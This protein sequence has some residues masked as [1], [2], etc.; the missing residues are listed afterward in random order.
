MKRG[1]RAVQVINAILRPTLRRNPDLKAAWVNAKA[2]S[3]P[4]G[5]G[6]GVVIPLA[7]TQ[8]PPPAAE[9]VTAA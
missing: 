5:G 3:Q 6:P 1:A 2:R 4:A 7:S 9:A 8:S